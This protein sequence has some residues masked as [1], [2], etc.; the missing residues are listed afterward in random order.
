LRRSLIDEGSIVPEEGGEKLRF[1]SH[2]RFKSPS[3]AAA[4]ILHRNSSS[5]V[6][7]R[8]EATGQAL[9]EW[10]DLQLVTGSVQD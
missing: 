10:Q 3:A 5:R 2:A 1:A 4:G 8:V 7:W 6:G 9:K